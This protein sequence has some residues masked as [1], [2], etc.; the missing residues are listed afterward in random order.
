ME[1][2]N[3]NPFIMQQFA[4]RNAVRPETAAGRRNSTILS[5]LRKESG[6]QKKLMRQRRKRGRRQITDSSCW[7]KWKRCV[8]GIKSGEHSAQDSDRRRGL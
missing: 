1:I 7:R 8:P 2:A 3:N 4:A 6:A 5:G